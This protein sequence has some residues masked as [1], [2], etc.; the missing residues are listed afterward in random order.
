[1]VIYREDVA[2]SA[3]VIANVN[4]NTGACMND[5]GVA[6]TTMGM[7]NRAS[8][9]RMDVNDTSVTSA[10][11]MELS[12]IDHL[13]SCS[14]GSA[15]V[16]VIYATGSTELIANECVN[17]FASANM[18]ASAKL[19]AARWTARANRN[20]SESAEE[21]A[22]SAGV[23]ATGTA[24]GPRC[25]MVAALTATSPGPATARAGT[26]TGPALATDIGATTTVRTRGLRSGCISG[27]A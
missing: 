9:S 19:N 10:M 22:A 2:T 18:S 15:S 17:R 24:P 16:C 25:M 21:S 14:N 11:A 13:S 4:L 26:T 27:Q 1:M 5:L 20:E 7:N 12:S 6:T 8:L 3:K 23:G